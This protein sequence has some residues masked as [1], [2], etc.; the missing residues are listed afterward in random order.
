MKID[1]N[2]EGNRIILYGA[3]RRYRETFF[4]NTTPF[5]ILTDWMEQIEKFEADQELFKDLI[6]KQ[7]ERE[8]K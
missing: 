5:H 1:L 3:L 8:A 7:E 6:K 4:N 2:D